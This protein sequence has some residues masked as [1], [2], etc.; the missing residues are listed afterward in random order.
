VVAAALSLVVLSSG[1]LTAGP[2]FNRSGSSGR[3]LI[4]PIPAGQTWYVCQGYNG[5]LTHED[6]P[7]LD[8]SLDPRSAGPRGCIGGS[9]YSSAGS[10][11]TSPA[12][13]TAFRWPG[14]CG[15][16]FVCV[17]LDAGGS[18]AIGHLSDRLTSGTRVGTATPIGTVAWPKPANG[19]YAHI[20]VQAHPS[21]DCTEGSDPVPFDSAHGFR[22]WCTRDLPYS[23]VVNQYS[24][25]AVSRCSSSHEGGPEEREAER[26]EGG[27]DPGDKPPT[28]RSQLEDMVENVMGSAE[29]VS[30]SWASTPPSRW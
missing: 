5:Q 30:S 11:V 28:W 25:I 27:L 9:R 4:L 13:G 8:L 26:E 6:T 14:C 1:G 2:S 29:R 3:P 17:N 7:A 10:V 23:G 19:D 12:A 15:D 21:P 24:G 22:W 16:D 18:I 20:H